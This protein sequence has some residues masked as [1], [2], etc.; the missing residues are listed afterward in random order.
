[1]RSRPPLSRT[2][3]S[4]TL[5]TPAPGAYSRARYRLQRAP[6][7]QIRCRRLRPLRPDSGDGHPALPAPKTACAHRRRQS[8][9]PYDALLRPRDGG[10]K[11]GRTGHLR[12]WYGRCATS[13]TRPSLSTLRRGADRGLPPRRRRM[14]DQFRGLTDDLLPRIVSG[15]RPYIIAVD[16]R[17]GSGKPLSRG[18]LPPPCG[19]T[20]CR[21]GR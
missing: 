4:V 12:P 7:I 13:S 9:N 17:S 6:R 19:S 1:M 18:A 21:A 15:P 3:R 5:S 14:S 11:P 10:Q 2:T 20:R 8:Q 16:G